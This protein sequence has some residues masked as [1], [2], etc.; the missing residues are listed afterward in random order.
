MPVEAAASTEPLNRL[1]AQ[2]GVAKP[3]V[4]VVL[5]RVRQAVAQQRYQLAIGSDRLPLRH[6][7]TPWSRLPGLVRGR[8]FRPHK[9]HWPRLGRVA[10]SLITA[11]VVAVGVVVV[12]LVAGRTQ[13]ATAPS[14]SYAFPTA[15][16]GSG[17][18]VNRSWTLS[19]KDGSQL[20]GEIVLANSLGSV[21]AG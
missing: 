17:L 9:L 21:L 19:G 14:T 12:L 5:R 7:E 16:Y 2:P 4:F 13:R 1:P 10:E 6:I 15:S 8:Q 3:A 11:A 20:S 18:V